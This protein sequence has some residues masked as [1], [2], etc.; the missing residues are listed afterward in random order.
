MAFD[1]MD[2]GK[3]SIPSPSVLK[4]ATTISTGGKKTYTKGGLIGLKKKEAMKKNF[5][6]K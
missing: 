5:L 3:T 4:T 2:T 6:K 1:A